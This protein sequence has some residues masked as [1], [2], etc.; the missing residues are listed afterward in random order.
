MN[1]EDIRAADQRLNAVLK[2][3]PVLV[4]AVSGGIDSLTLATIAH[5]QLSAA[6]LMVHALSPAVPAAATAR[7]Q[8]LAAREGWNLEE[9]EAGE[10]ED[11]EYRANPYNRCYFCKS[12]LYR[13]ICTLSDGQIASGANLDD[14]S[15]YRPGLIAA[16][17]QNVVHPF[18]EAGID[19]AT[20][21]ELARRHHLD[22][23]A[24]LPAQPCLASRVETGVPIRPH[25][26]FF[27]DT[28]E[29]ALH[30]I[31]GELATIRVRVRLNGVF[32]ELGEVPDSQANA[33]VCDRAREICQN[34]GYH[35]M[36]ITGYRQGSAFVKKA[37]V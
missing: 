3:Y 19:K 35:F 4:I 10:F 29:N 24:D 28:L 23:Y 21:R 6:P 7:V 36:G 25:D 14:L 15:D 26:M 22:A 37:A 1:E 31:L 16:S 5:R 2:A 33:G 12:N 18:V 27:I 13:A 32:V 20:I 30:R 34:A 8:E 17:E 9:I 11:P